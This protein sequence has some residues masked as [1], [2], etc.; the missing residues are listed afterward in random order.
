VE[1]AF[2]V[3]L[4]GMD[5]SGAAVAHAG[6]ERLL[7]HGAIRGEVVRV[8]RSRAVGHGTLCELVEIVEPSPH[9]LA[10]RCRHASVCGGCSWQHIAYAEQLRIKA[11]V[12]EA[13]LR[14]ALGEGAPSVA[15]LI[16]TPV[17]GEKMP[18]GFRQKATFVF[19]DGPSG[20]VMG[21]FARGTHDVVPIEEC[22]VHPERANR[23]AFA[24]R[25]ELRQA[26]VTAAGERLEGVARHVLVRT[27]RDEREAV[28]LLV[29]TRQ[30]PELAA[31]LAALLGRPE[32]PD[33]LAVNLHARPGPYLLGRETRR[34]AGS[35][36]VREDALGPV[37]LV[38]ATAFFQTNVAAAAILL[39]L[40]TA[41]LPAAS[42]L[43][44]L[45]LYSGA[46]L[47]A[48][49][50]ALRGHLV[51]AVEES[52]KGVADALLNR[53]ENAV[54]E[55]RLRLVPSTVERALPRFQPH[56]F[57][58]V[59]LD[60]PREG[61]PPQVLRDVCGRLRP[62]RVVLVSCNPDALA[63]ELPAALG[64]GYRLVRVQG[65]DMFPHTPHVE[66][67]AVLERRPHAGARS[68]GRGRSRAARP[69]TRS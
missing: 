50:L 11:H 25:D 51:T 4:T 57:D 14:R 65:V 34:V 23:I 58:A 46:G 64:A 59:V 3:A 43:R 2:D 55:D 54:P 36:R 30:G 37:F 19:A 20:L 16:G 26:G 5:R 28:A 17:A 24:L 41:A 29:A 38:A 44:V 13:A 68:H 39:E 60:P 63:R 8:R 66:A 18:W 22:P 6:S 69:A 31:P 61:S 35:G 45:D 10:A 42:G 7:V 32:R 48:L 52:R 33:G 1:G 53:R 56:A 47:F 49:P 21:H 62:R 40:V 15:P 9:R 12:L 27:T 67:V